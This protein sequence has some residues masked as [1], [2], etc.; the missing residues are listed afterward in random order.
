MTSSLCN[1]SNSGLANNTLFLSLNSVAASCPNKMGVLP[2]LTTEVARDV[3]ALEAG[4][5][6]GVTAFKGVDVEAAVTGPL[7]VCAGVTA[8]VPAFVAPGKTPLLRFRLI[9]LVNSVLK[10]SR[11]EYATSCGVA[12]NVKLCPTSSLTIPILS[13]T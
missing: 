8:A 11:S 9:T 3:E 6:A 12:V 7:S 10:V 4:S 13:L 2:S 1:A 5:T